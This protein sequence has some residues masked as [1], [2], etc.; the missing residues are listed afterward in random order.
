MMLCECFGGPRDGGTESLPDSCAV[1][2]VYGITTAHFAEAH[3]FAEPSSQNLI[4]EP[5]AVVALYQLNGISSQMGH[6]DFKGYA[7]SKAA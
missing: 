1:G 7:K 6:L 4:P 5:L 2:F 3:P